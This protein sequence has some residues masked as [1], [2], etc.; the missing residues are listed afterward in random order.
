MI[1]EV[2]GLVIR[3]TDIRES[4]RLITIFTE[5]MGVLS[6]LAQG[7]RSLKS[8]KMS[9]TMQ[10][11]YSRFFLFK[12]GEHY[13]VREAEL[14][15]SFFDLRNSI[16]GLALASYIADVLSDVTVATEEKELLR[17]SLNSLFAIANKKY[18]LNKIKAA[19]EIRAASILGFMPD[20]LA[21]S[22]CGEKGGNFYFD[23]MGGSIKC[24]ACCE[25]ERKAHTEPESPHESHIVRILSEGAKTALAYC[26]FAPIEKIFSFTLPDGDMELFAGACEDYLINQLER[27]FKT[28]EFYKEVT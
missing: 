9:S 5:E 18:P 25:R 1:T 10:F 27:S 11:C 28:L 4:D 15:E 20:V 13:Y 6:A 26:I 2:K 23:I 14:I 19:F 12:K 21:C 22:A 8:R 17:L 3:T 24:Y 7:A 16:E